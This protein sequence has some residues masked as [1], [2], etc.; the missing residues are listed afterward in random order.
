MEEGVLKSRVAEIASELR[1]RGDVEF[2]KDNETF[3]LTEAGYVRAKSLN[4][5]GEL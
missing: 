5:K 1:I 2:S 4:D 3:W